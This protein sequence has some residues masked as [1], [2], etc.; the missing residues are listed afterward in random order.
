MLYILSCTSINLSILCLALRLSKK[1]VL[2]MQGEYLMLSHKDLN[3]ELLIQNQ[4]RYHY[5]MRHAFISRLAIFRNT[6]KMK[7]V[8]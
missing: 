2:E 1:S 7:I 3:F 5:A 4:A 6:A 8:L